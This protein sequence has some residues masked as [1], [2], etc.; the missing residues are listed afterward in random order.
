MVSLNGALHKM[1]VKWFIYSMVVLC[2]T[3]VPLHYSNT[4]SVRKYKIKLLTLTI[5]LEVIRNSVARSFTSFTLTD[6]EPSRFSSSVN[7]LWRAVQCFGMTSL[8]AWSSSSILDSCLI[9]SSN[10]AFP[11]ESAESVNSSS[12]SV[13]KNKVWIE[14]K[15]S[16]LL[17]LK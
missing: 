2:H 10:S 17:N 13:N 1:S 11:L 12:S 3:G 15:K 6:S 16:Y 8:H 4:M 5:A 7:D 9:M 14:K